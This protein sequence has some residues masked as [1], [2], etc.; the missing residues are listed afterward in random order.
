MEEGGEGREEEEEGGMRREGGGNDGGEWR[1]V[2]WREGGTI[3]WG[4]G[5]GSVRRRREEGEEKDE[6]GGREGDASLKLNRD[7]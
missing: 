4:W 6:E 1:E 7:T 2:G 5:E 3:R